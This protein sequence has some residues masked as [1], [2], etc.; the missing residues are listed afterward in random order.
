MFFNADVGLR[1][2][3]GIVSSTAALQQEHPGFK[4]YT[5][6]AS[7]LHAPFVGVSPGTLTSSHIQKHDCE[8]SL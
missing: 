2:H 8:V 1:L 5:L 4:S 3:C 7:R 6:S